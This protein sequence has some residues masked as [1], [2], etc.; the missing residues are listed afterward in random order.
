MDI[1]PSP[2][3]L[4][5]HI[6][7]IYFFFICLEYLSCVLCFGYVSCSFS[8]FSSKFNINA[9]WRSDLCTRWGRARG[10]K[11]IGGSWEGTDVLTNIS[12]VREGQETRLKRAS[13]CSTLFL[14]RKVYCSS[15]RRACRS[16]LSLSLSNSAHQKSPKAFFIEARAS[17][18]FY[19][20]FYV[21]GSRIWTKII[22][23]FSSED[24]FEDQQTWTLDPT[25]EKVLEVVHLTAFI[26]FR[27]LSTA[28]CEV[29]FLLLE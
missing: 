23:R 2:E 1:D 3:V 17:P 12:G 18:T 24:F 21:S 10:S 15:C 5:I 27:S 8:P 29:N 11:R 25:E 7:Q 28:C 19:D 13:F 6:D 9:S 4:S 14:Q 16:L 26:I 22:S 20:C